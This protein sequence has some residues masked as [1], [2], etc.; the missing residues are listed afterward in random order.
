MVIT[1]HQTLAGRRAAV[2]VAAAAGTGLW[3]TKR[4]GQAL[5]SGAGMKLV[6]GCF[7]RDYYEHDKIYG[8]SNG[9]CGSGRCYCRSGYGADVAQV[10]SDCA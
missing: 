3:R 6:V 7:E 8:E 2:K 4:S 5:V 9:C 1:E 10:I